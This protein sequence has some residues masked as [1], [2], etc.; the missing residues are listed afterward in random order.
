MIVQMRQLRNR[1]ERG[2]ALIIAV[3]MLVGLTG[4][5]MATIQSSGIGFSEARAVAGTLGRSSCQ[6]QVARYVIEQLERENLEVV[7]ERINAGTCNSAAV[8]WVNF[9]SGI[10]DGPDGET[11]L[12]PTPSCNPDIGI[13]STQYQY[14]PCP[15]TRAI[16][17]VAPTPYTPGGDIV[18]ESAG[19]SSGGD[20]IRTPVRVVV[21][22]LQSC[23]PRSLNSYLD[24]AYVFSRHAGEGAGQRDF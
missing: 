17:L 4:L 23:D 14:L 20:E 21:A 10:P 16:A 3:F 12:T 2:I 22:D 19:A 18:G 13:A 6:D 8:A 9:G 11:C 24:I 5:A 1:S 7:A 15:D